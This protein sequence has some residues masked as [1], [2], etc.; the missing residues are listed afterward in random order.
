M[1]N[2]V[3]D[4]AKKSWSGPTVRRHAPAATVLVSHIHLPT[5]KRVLFCASC[6]AEWPD[7]EEQA[8]RVDC[9]YLK[10]DA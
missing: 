5:L 1:S 9:R 2:T 6:W 10:E 8:H 7:G 4:L 3:G